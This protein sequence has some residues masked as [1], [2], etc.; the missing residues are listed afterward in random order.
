MPRCPTARAGRDVVSGGTR[1]MFNSTAGRT[2]VVLLLSLAGSLAASTP[3]R[4]CRGR[5]G[6]SGELT[7]S[8]GVANP[9]HRSRRLNSWIECRTSK[10]E[11]STRR[12][13]SK[14][15]EERNHTQTYL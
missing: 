6:V 10:V 9:H 15:K 14:A 11:K 5:E 13:Q 2:P 1:E 8:P 4:S 3:A 7:A 12:A